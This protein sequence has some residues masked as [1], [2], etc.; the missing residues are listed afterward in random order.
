MRSFL[1]SLS[2]TTAYKLVVYYSRSVCSLST[3]GYD[4]AESVGQVSV[5]CR[6]SIG[7]VSINCRSN[8][9][10]VS[11][12]YRSCSS[13]VSV[14]YRW[15]KTISVDYRPTIDRYIDRYIGRLSVGYRSTV[16]R[17]IDRVHLWY[18]R[19]GDTRRTISLLCCNGP[20]VCVSF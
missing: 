11:V 20:F 12:K 3:D 14:E 5:K 17:Y 16:D 4:T 7:E 2:F 13:H 10:Q 15:T 19:S 8:I 9:G 1:I 18:T 6:L